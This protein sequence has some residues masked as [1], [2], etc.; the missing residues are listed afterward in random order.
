M[1]LDMYLNA[2]RFMWH[3]EDEL[4]AT[5]AQAF[6]ELKGRRVKQV[7]VEAMY[8]R[9][10]NAIHKWFVDNVQEGNDDCGD[11]WVS[12]EQLETLRQ[13]ILEVL[14]TK[15]ASLLPPQVG[16]FF[17]S[18]DVDEWYWEDLR[19]TADGLEKALNEFPESWDFEYH[20][21]W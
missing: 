15:D 21:S 7:I 4:A 5:V 20:S 13:L 3:T 14:D 8:W 12:R 1:G 11:Y 2:K 9:K 17:G 6:P 19:R 18:T 10:C 16:F